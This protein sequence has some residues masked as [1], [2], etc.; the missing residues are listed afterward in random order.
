MLTM[1]LNLNATDVTALEEALEKIKAEVACGVTL[2]RA[3]AGDFN[4]E[5]EVTPAEDEADYP[6]YDYPEYDYPEYDYDGQPD[7]AQEW[8]DFNP[9]A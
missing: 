4:Y 3:R 6:E 1:T 2:S 9:D 8:H 7:E 5:F